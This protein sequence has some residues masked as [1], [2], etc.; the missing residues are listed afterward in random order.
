MLWT[1][2]MLMPLIAAAFAILMMGQEDDGP[3]IGGP[4]ELVMADGSPITEQALDG[5]FTFIYF[6]YTS[7]PDVCPTS[8]ATLSTALDAMPKDKQQKTQTFFVSVDPDRDQGEDLEDYAKTFHDTFIGVTGTKEQIDSM[9][10]AYKAYYKIDKSQD[11]ELYPVDHSSI[12]Y[13]MGTDGRYVAH[14]THNSPPERIT[15]KLEE[16][17]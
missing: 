7:C 2:V 15:K 4:F 8:L 6:G 17:L 14:F 16:I 9:V 11:P 12:L 1:W 3:T 5:R 10:A 13:L